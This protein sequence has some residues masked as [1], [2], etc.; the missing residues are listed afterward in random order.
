[1]E[2]IALII[3]LLTMTYLFFTISEFIYGFN[4]IKNLSK[5][6]CLDQSQLP[7]VSII[8]SALD[9]EKDIENVL[10]N[11]MKLEYSNL[12]IIAVNDRSKDKTPEIMERLK[13][14]HLHIYHI[15]QLPE[16][17]FGKNHA[18]HVASK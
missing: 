15:N 7:S 18:L 10:T 1:M 16:G 2:L 3:A 17:W 14:K 5:Q 12:E 9:E 4:K 8:F 6:S 13:Q 11:F